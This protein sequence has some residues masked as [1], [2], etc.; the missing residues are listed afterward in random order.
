M[1]VRGDT[2]ARCADLLPRPHCVD[3]LGLWVEEEEEEELEQKEGFVVLEA[4]APAGSWLPRE[5]H[6]C[7]T[8]RGDVLPS[9]VTPGAGTPEDAQ[10]FWDESGD[11]KSVV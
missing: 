1:T 6:S 7:L 2:L 3:W 11:R 4:G 5:S 9:L 10:G 8:R